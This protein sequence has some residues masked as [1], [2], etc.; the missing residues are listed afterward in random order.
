MHRT[1]GDLRRVVIVTL[2]LLSCSACGPAQV[3]DVSRLIEVSGDAAY[4][5]LTNAINDS[6]PPSCGGAARGTRDNPRLVG[7]KVDELITALGGR[8]GG[9]IVTARQE[10]DEWFLEEFHAPTA[11]D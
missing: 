7:E 5:C 11:R 2:G 3:V 10:G 4:L 9:A 1:T 8:S 6:D